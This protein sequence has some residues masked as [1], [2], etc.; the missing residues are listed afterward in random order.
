MS[1]RACGRCG[2]AY[3]DDGWSA[4]ERCGEVSS[5]DVRP[6]LTTVPRELGIDLRRCRACATVLARFGTPR[7]A[8]SA[9]RA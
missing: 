4:L 3:D 7:D 2:A 9:A 5:D 1:L 6:H 8:P